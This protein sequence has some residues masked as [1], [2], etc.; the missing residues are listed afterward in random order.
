MVAEIQYL[1]FLHFFNGNNSSCNIIYVF[2]RFH[3]LLLKI[4]FCN[5]T[6]MNGIGVGSLHFQI[7]RLHL[8]Q[9]YM[10]IIRAALISW[11]SAVCQID[12]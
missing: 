2:S 4:E 3:Y 1:I 6:L 7:T 10:M 12:V 5:D 8:K 11:V 9:Y